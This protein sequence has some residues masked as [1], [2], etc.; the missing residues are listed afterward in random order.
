MARTVEISFLNKPRNEQGLKCVND[1]RDKEKNKSCE[2]LFTALTSIVFPTP[3]FLFFC[4]CL[5]SYKDGRRNLDPYRELLL[6]LKLVMSVQKLTD[7]I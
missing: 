2:Q 4:L 5:H 3:Y 6:G 7:L 1:A